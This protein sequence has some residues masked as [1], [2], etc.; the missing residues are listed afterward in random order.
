[1]EDAGRAR[2]TSFEGELY[3]LDWLTSHRVDDFTL[4]T[5]KKQNTCFRVERD[6]AGEKY[7]SYYYYYYY[8]C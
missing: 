7:D 3:H 1:M 5:R 2:R 4:Q 8:C 6:Y